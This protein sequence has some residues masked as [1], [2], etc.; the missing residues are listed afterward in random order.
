MLAGS[1]SNL[2]FAPFGFWPQQIITLAL[3]IQLLVHAPTIK[4]AA[5]IGRVYSFSWFA[6]GVY[7]LYVSM[8]R[9]GGLPAW[10]SVLAVALLAAVLAL[11]AALMMGVGYWLRQRLRASM[12]VSLLLINHAMW[13]LSEWLSG[14]VLNGI[15]WVV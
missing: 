4:R 14:W 11:F 8:H 1:V 9:Y 13:M 7:W 3:L 6:C 10:M 15:P 2:A 5:L 12:A